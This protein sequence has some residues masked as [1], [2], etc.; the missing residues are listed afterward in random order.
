MVVAVLSI[1][2]NTQS[3]KE[4]VDGTDKTSNKR[5][6]LSFL[7]INVDVRAAGKDLIAA[8]WADLDATRLAVSVLPFGAW[9]SSHG[10]S[11]GEKSGDS[12]THRDG[13][14]VGK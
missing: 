7:D 6:Q 2:A 13:Y 12:E 8:L 14:W 4:S 3:T 9:D 11:Q 1:T 5:V 10:H